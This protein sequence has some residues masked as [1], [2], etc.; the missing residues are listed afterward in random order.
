MRFK[1]N[2]ADGKTI[3]FVSAYSSPGHVCVKLY[4]L[5]D[6][7]DWETHSKKAKFAGDVTIRNRK[8]NLWI[9]YVDGDLGYDQ[10]ELACMLVRAGVVS[11]PDILNDVEDTSVSYE[12]EKWGT[13][14]LPLIPGLDGEGPKKRIPNKAST[15]RVCKLHAPIMKVIAEEEEC[16]AKRPKIM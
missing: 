14:K 5:A 13:E 4:V 7:E 1:A 6:G 11:H 2:N 10:T 8:G 15:E 12:I 16:S 9:F 3:G